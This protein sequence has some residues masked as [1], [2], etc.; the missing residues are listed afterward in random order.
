V[1]VRFT[2]EEANALLPQV[3]VL[4]EGMVAAAAHADAA[5]QRRALLLRHITGNGGDIVP[6]EVAEAARDVE[7]A[8]AELRRA[9]AALIELGIQVKDP[10]TGLVDFPALRH[11]ED[12]LLCWQLGEPEVAFWHTAEGGFAGRRPLP[13]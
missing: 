13:L 4:V 5:E 2:P 3:R 1:A 12:V 7:E 11:G 6:S 8:E 10:H 9:I